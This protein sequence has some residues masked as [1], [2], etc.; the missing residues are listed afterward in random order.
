MSQ[1]SKDLAKTAAVVAAVVVEWRLPC[2]WRS[3]RHSAGSVSFSSSVSSRGAGPSAA[4]FARPTEADEEEDLS[5][6]EL[7]PSTDRDIRGAAAVAVALAGRDA[8]VAVA[9]AL[10]GDDDDDE[11]DSNDC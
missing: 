6:A 5:A 10:A 11:G 1:L 7:A 3:H 9:V 8:A 2:S 4:V